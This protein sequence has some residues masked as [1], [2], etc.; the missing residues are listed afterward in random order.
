V[1][2]KLLSKE[3]QQLIWSWLPIRQRLKDA[4]LIYCSEKHGYN[5]HTLYRLSDQKI[6]EQEHRRGAAETASLLIIKTGRKEVLG[7]YTNVGWQHLE[8]YYGNGECFV[9]RLSPRPRCWKWSQRNDMMMLACNKSL[10]IGAGSEPALWLDDEI[11]QGISSACE[12]F[13]NPPLTTE[14]Q[15]I[16]LPAATDA[17][18]QKGKP[19]SQASF[20]CV[21]VELYMLL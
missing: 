2:G 19:V 10:S 17:A 8:H 14:E 12:T 15:V 18:G 1:G 5:L 20:R 11:S 6:K 7:V 13:G 4:T 21:A 16:V 3:E 9:F